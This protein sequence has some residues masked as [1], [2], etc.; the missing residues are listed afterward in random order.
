MLA[1][2]TTPIWTFANRDWYLFRKVKHLLR[3]HDFYC[4]EDVKDSLQR[5]VKSL[6][7]DEL[8]QQLKKLRDKCE[9]V[10]EAGGDYVT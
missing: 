4:R 1:G 9:A 10:I 7:E 2:E 6:P 3:N 8:Y 5:V